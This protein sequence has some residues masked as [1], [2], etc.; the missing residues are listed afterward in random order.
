MRGVEVEGQL[1]GEGVDEEAGVAEGEPRAAADGGGLEQRVG[2]A[3]GALHGLDGGA[4]AA[5]G[6]A[7][8]LLCVGLDD[9][10]G[11][12]NVSGVLLE[13]AQG[14][15]L[16]ELFEAVLF[17]GGDQPCPLP[18]GDLPGMQVQDPEYVL[19]GISGH[20]GVSVKPSFKLKVAD[21][22]LEYASDAC[23]VQGLSGPLRLK[24]RG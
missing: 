19:T 5:G 8:S 6:D 12:S 13:I 1:L 18:R 3:G 7:G 4:D 16:S 17:S 24:S 2:H 20:V 9:G 10:L 15:E 14:A 11:S 22:C 21:F 23:V